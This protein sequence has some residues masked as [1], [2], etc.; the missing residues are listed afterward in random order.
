METVPR[1]RVI[2]HLASCRL[3][4]GG[5]IPRQRTHHLA[6]L[7]ASVDH[8]VSFVG[9]EDV[10]LL[11]VEGG[12]CGPEDP[13][14]VE[15]E[16]VVCGSGDFRGILQDSYDVYLADAGGGFALEDVESC[17]VSVVGGFAVYYILGL[18]LGWSRGGG[19][20]MSEVNH[21][22]GVRQLV[23]TS[24]MDVI[25]RTAQIPLQ[26]CYVGRRAY[27]HCSNGLMVIWICIIYNPGVICCALYIVISSYF[28]TRDQHWVMERLRLV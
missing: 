27:P 16:T 25:L 28:H 22:V 10:R 9:Q 19:L 14:M 20:V 8:G 4:L 7:V 18:M 24:T 6:L 17:C 21:N 5:I 23:G 1:F 11:V 26:G 13:G 2:L 12:S 3:Q 15:A